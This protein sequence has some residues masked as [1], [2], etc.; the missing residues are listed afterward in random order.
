MD[1]ATERERIAA[2]LMMEG[3]CNLVNDLHEAYHTLK[4][5]LAEDRVTLTREVK[6]PI[7]REAIIATIDLCRSTFDKVFA[8]WD[9]DML[10]AQ[11]QQASAKINSLLDMEERRN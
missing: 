11:Y 5:T 4:E 9:C 7:A 8:N 10:E 3:F 6:D 1:K 2:N